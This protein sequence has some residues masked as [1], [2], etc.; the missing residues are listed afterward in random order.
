M[1]VQIE[2][3]VY[4]QIDEFVINNSLSTSLLINDNILNDIDNFNDLRNNRSSN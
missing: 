3:R 2:P 1:M 4:T